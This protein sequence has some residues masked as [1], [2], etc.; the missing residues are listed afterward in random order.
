MTTAH[1]K[2][3][4]SRPLPSLAPTLMLAEKKV[5]PIITTNMLQNPFRASDGTA[6]RE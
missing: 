1:A 3:P 2:P 6:S 5:N 4:R